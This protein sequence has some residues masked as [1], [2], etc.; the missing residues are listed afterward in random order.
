MTTTR[1]RS[2][3][4]AV[5]GRPERWELRIDVAPGPSASQRAS[6]RDNFAAYAAYAWPRLV[7]TARLLTGGGRAAEHLARATLAETYAR[8]RRIPRKDADFHVRR[9]LVR[10]YLRLARRRSVGAGHRTPLLGMLANLP[11]RQRVVLVLRYGEGLAESEIAQM[12][13][14]SVGAVTSYTRRGLAALADCPRAEPVDE[15]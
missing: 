13:G 7:C 10:R 15:S 12:L 4:A 14:C 6:P 8:R 9:T 11:A 5:A 3:R 1:A 2:R